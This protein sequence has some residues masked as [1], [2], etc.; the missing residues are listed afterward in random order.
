MHKHIKNPKWGSFPSKV[1]VASL[2]FACL[3]ELPILCSR[4]YKMNSEWLIYLWLKPR[5]DMNY[6]GCV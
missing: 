2:I 5:P 4:V 3:V 1:S 6:K